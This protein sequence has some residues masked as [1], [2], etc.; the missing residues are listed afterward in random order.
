[1]AAFKLC[2]L[3]CVVILVG[4]I[5][6]HLLPLH[7]FSGGVKT[8]HNGQMKRDPTHHQMTHVVLS[9]NTFWIFHTSRSLPF[10]T[11]CTH[12]DNW[13]WVQP[14]PVRYKFN[15]RKHHSSHLTDSIWVISYFIFSIEQHQHLCSTS[16]FPS[17]EFETMIGGAKSAD[18][19]GP[20]PIYSYSCKTKQRLLSDTVGLREAWAPILAVET[21]MHQP[22]CNALV[23]QLI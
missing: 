12:H 17:E 4:F 18:L 15:A 20:G 10:G 6:P 9:W 5:R 1:M 13:W 23:R 14:N 8:I 22:H 21:I 19:S 7:S 2:Q 11:Y 3:I 16:C